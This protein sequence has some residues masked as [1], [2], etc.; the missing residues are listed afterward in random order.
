MVRRS[1]R[2]CWTC[3]RRHKK[4]DEERPVCK[5]CT[6]AGM[7]CE[8]YETRLTWGP[9]TTTPPTAGVVLNPVRQSRLQK[10]ARVSKEA[11]ATNEELPD[12][13]MD[14]PDLGSVSSPDQLDLLYLQ[15]GGNDISGT[16]TLPSDDVSHSLME[17]FASTGYQTLTGRAG[18]DT[19]LKSDILPLCDT[20]VPLRQVC[21]AYQAS[22]DT[23]TMKWTPMYMQSALSY[24]FDDLNSPEKL[25]LDATLAT[26]VLLCSV[27]INSLYIWTPL[28][29][30]LHG[31]LQ[32]RGLLNTAQ[33]SPL[34]DHLVEVVALLDIP[35]FTVNRI[36]RS[37]DVWKMHVGPNRQLG[38][39]QTSGLPYTLITLLADLGS[40]QAEE[41]LL[42]WPGELGS[43]FIQIHL[44]D[45]FRY[46][47]ILH[48]RALLGDMQHPH[49]QSTSKPRTEV[50]R[51]KAFAAIQ[52]IVDSGA[53]TFRQPLARAI[54]YPLF[55]SGLLAENELEQR[56]TRIAFQH[57]TEDGQ[58]TTDKV[59]LNI[60]MKIWETGKGRSESSKLGLAL[61]LAA[62]RNVE[63]HLY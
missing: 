27:S 58:E 62:E 38:I 42:Q 32:H 44:W 25:D 37:L 8:G 29:K 41:C 26:G 24:Y 4:C 36:S 60:V 1:R 20:S 35:C 10:K 2:G 9:D 5:R 55:I 31:V 56:L 47:G 30:G 33:R 57:L 6:Q 34:A 18:Q 19:L 39:E 61:E 43:D 14:M 59:A 3:K 7:N 45:A 46:A 22:L 48:S 52:A 23:E 15:Y 54:L 28:L 12:F 21:L 16:V 53:F 17:N 49:S 40:L 50:L 11:D 63:I 51:M 13:S